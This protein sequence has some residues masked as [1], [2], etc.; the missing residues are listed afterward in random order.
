[1]ERYLSDMEAIMIGREIQ[2]PGFQ[3]PFHGIGKSKNILQKK[4]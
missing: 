2:K 1:M 3:K 4:S